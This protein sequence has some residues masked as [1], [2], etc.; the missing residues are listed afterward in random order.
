[1]KKVLEGFNFK[2]PAYIFSSDDFVQMEKT[3]NSNLSERNKSDLQRA[4]SEYQFLEASWKIAASK[5]D[6]RKILAGV[7]KDVVQLMGTL[8]SLHA[9]DPSDQST[10]DKISSSGPAQQSALQLLL[11]FG[12]ANHWSSDYRDE[13]LAYAENLVKLAREPKSP[14]QEMALESLFASAPA[15]GWSEKYSD[16]MFAFT[17]CLAKLGQAATIALEENPGNKGGRPDNLPINTLCKTLMNLFVEITNSDPTVN[18][19]SSKSPENE[20]SGKSINFVDSFLSSLDPYYHR[21]PREL[22]LVLKVIIREHKH[23]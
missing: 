5:K 6:V 3:L 8:H 13:M 2:A 18:T 11:N 15:K 4:C 20:F 1:M 17:E 10:S 23:P 12:P 16:E 9:M 21:S 19:D 14:D 7:H 22:G